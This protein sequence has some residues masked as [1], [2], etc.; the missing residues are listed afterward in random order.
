MPADPERIL[1]EALALPA[2]E[3]AS[4]IESL[5]ASLDRP[6][7]AIDSLWAKEAEDRIAAYDAAGMK[8]VDADEVFAEFEGQ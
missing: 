3:R 6:D 5:L 4:L 1:S 7:P 8:A 2:V